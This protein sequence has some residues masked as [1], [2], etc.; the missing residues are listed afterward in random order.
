MT[1]GNTEI[2]TGAFRA[3][4][5]TM[6]Y[7]QVLGRLC[8]GLPADLEYTLGLSETEPDIFLVRFSGQRH[9]LTVIDYR[10]KINLAEQVAYQGDMTIDPDMQRQHAGTY[11][12]CNNLL[13]RRDCGIRASKFQTDFMGGYAWPRMGALL[14]KDPE[15]TQKLDDA[16]RSILIELDYLQRRLGTYETMPD[17][18]RPDGLWAVADMGQSGFLD[19]LNGFF[20]KAA[21]SGCEIWDTLDHRLT[22]RAALMKSTYQSDPP[23]ITVGQLVLYGKKVPCYFDL[24]GEG[25]EAQ[26]QWQRIRSYMSAR[27]YPGV[28]FI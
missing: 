5:G 3:V 15:V 17:L 22:S 4:F 2:E 10:Q 23:Q 26:R 12:S 13:L 21:A 25:P 27:A 11:L 7:D 18:E 6:T 9:S 16:K 19:R 28:D 14:D 8:L 24:Q 20:N 1:H